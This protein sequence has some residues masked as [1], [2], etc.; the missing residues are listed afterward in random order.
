MVMI[1]TPGCLLAAGSVFFL[2]AAEGSQ[3]MVLASVFAICTGFGLG[4]TPPTCY[5]AAADCFGGRNYGSI[6]GVIILSV[7]LGSGVG[8]WLGG[9]LHDITGTYT[10][11]FVLVQ[12]ALVAAG[13]LMWVA[14]PSRTTLKLD[15]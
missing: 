2:Y 10:S 15:T 9:Y 6:Q 11:T 4:I 12:V 7:A 13:L 1:F 5:A 8:P 14:R 3:S